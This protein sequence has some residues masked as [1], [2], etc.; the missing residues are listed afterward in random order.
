MPVTITKSQSSLPFVMAFGLL[1]AALLWIAPM[2]HAQQSSALK[3]HDTQQP[4]DVTAEN[5]EVRAK[6]GWALFSG[7]VLVKQGGLTMK[8]GQMRVFY[9]K[10]TLDDN[11]EIDRLDAIG[12]V[13]FTSASETVSAERAIYDVEKR[14]VTMLGKIV[15]TRGETVLKG[16]RL[17]LNLVTGL[18]K[19][20]GEDSKGTEGRVRGVFSLP[21]DETKKEKK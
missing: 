15:M 9:D 6:E 1:I 3:G 14:L 21:K 7:L 16:D 18:T 5:L 10:E 13:V 17:E 19:L 2:A 4:I 20:S 12:S 8:A 11:P